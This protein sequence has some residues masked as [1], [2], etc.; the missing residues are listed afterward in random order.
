MAFAHNCCFCVGGASG[1]CWVVGCKIKTGVD[2]CVC[3][4]I[5]FGRPPAGVCG[6]LRLVRLCLMVICLGGMSALRLPCPWRRAHTC[7]YVATRVAALR[8]TRR[9]VA[10]SRM[11]GRRRIGQRC[12]ELLRTSVHKGNPICGFRSS[13][14]RRRLVWWSCIAALSAMRDSA[15]LASDT[16][17]Y[18]SVGRSHLTPAV[19]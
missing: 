12:Q 15:V 6:L 13:N 11:V 3:K 1:A 14:A 4:S 8:E 7:E 19:V 9:A 17:L 18:A 16:S 5:G 10:A 2:P